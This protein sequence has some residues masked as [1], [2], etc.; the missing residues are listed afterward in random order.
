MRF[1]RFYTV[2]TP[3]RRRAL[4]GAPVDPV[5]P[6]CR[7]MGQ[8]PTGGRNG[9]DFTDRP[10]SALPNH[11]S[12]KADIQDRKYAKVTQILN[13]GKTLVSNITVI[14]ESTAYDLNTIG[15]GSSETRITD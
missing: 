11:K 5:L 12:S 13:E 2:R 3:Y 6:K 7:I 9:C 4:N 14:L 15:Q 1:Y 8:F 10:G